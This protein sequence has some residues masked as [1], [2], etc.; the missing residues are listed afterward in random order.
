MLTTIGTLIYVLY[1][2]AGFALL[3]IALIKSAPRISAPTLSAST[4][5]ELEQNR[6]RQRQLESRNE[7]SENGLPAKDRRELEAL[8][9]EERTLVRRERLAAE[10][11]GEGQ[12]WLVKAWTKTEA[13][14]RP[15]K[16]LGGVFLIIVA[17]FIWVCMLLTFIDKA[18]NSICKSHCG[19]VLGYTHI[20]NPMNWIL[21]KAA[22]VFPIDYVIYLLVVLFFFSSSVVGIT[23][24]G[25][26][27]LW[28]RIFQIRKGHTSPQAML[29]ATML[30][31]L[32][33]LAINYSMG[34]MVAPGYAHFGPQ[35]YCDRPLRHPTDQPDCT[36]HKRAIKPCSELAT[37]QAAKNVC[38]P[39]VFSTFM[40]RLTV[41]WSFFGDIS[42]WAQLAFLGTLSPLFIIVCSTNLTIA[43]FML[44]F[45]LSLFRTP[46][47]DEYQMD[48][49]AEEEEEES[50][51]AST[52]RRF[53]AT[54]QDITGRAKKTTG[55][56][57]HET[58][59]NGT[60]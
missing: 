19:Y 22:K 29:L 40:D 23:S 36:H 26:R 30:L 21:V 38:T 1:T 60:S 50:L 8:V 15:I 13:I 2:A 53:G 6:E 57:G 47:L 44:I 25:I 20:L 56:A 3:P 14:F 32:I 10:A 4:A 9:R 43:F 18:K 28:L 16:L 46:K 34:M 55:S 5:P 24:I 42:F 54:W 11:S 12:S 7:G 48:Q 51:L 58:G 49:D 33:V 45:L 31:A 39:T 52:G 17:L 35:T 27:F 59:D 41:N 37:S